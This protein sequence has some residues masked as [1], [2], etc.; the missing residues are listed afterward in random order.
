MPADGDLYLV[1]EV[2]TNVA[3]ARELSSSQRLPSPVVCVPAAPDAWRPF[4]VRILCLCVW[5]FCLRR[6]RASA[7][8][9]ALPPPSLLLSK[10]QQPK[11]YT[12]SLRGALG[13]DSNNAA[14]WERLIRA[15]TAGLP[16]VSGYNINSELCESN[17]FHHAYLVE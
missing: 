15:F 3:N 5:V 13:G 16:R 6:S 2:P 1:L 4:I 9:G 8:R 17:N 10:H 11:L 12:L 14:P 7:C